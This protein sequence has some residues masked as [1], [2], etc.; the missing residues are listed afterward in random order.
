MSGI[1]TGWRTWVLA[2]VLWLLAP[3]GASASYTG[4]EVELV[5]TSDYGWSYRVYATFSDPAD[6]VVAVYGWAPAPMALVSA[7]SIYQHP[8]GA[9]TALGLNTAL[10]GAYPD[11]VYDSWFTIGSES[12]DGS[13]ALNLAGMGT[14]FDAFESGEGFVL[15]DP[16]GGTWFIAPDSSPEAFAGEEGRVLL[17]QFTVTGLTSWTFNVQ[18]VDSAG[19]T[20][21]EEGLVVT[22]PQDVTFGCMDEE[23]CN[24]DPV[25]EAEDGSC[26]YLSCLV[27]GCTDPLACN[28][29]P[30]ATADDGDC[31]FCSCQRT[32]A[33]TLTVESSPSVLPDKTVHRFY[34]NT[35]DASDRVSA[36]FGNN[37]KE[38]RVDAPAGVFNST[39]NNS[40]N[41]SGVNP[42]LFGLYPELADD[43]YA[44]VGLSGPAS[45]SPNNGALDASLVQDVDQPITPFFQEDDA[46]LLLS[47]TVTGALWYV[48]NT[49]PNG[50][51]DENN[52]VLVMQVTSGGP[53]S[54]QLNVQ[55][56]PL[57]VGEDAIEVTLPFDGAGEFGGEQNSA[58][59]GCTDELA[60]NFDSEAEY[61]S[62][63]CFYDVL[64]CGDP[65]A[66]NYEA[67]VTLD[68]GSCDY[69]SCVV[70][71]C[72]D[73]EADNYD[74][75]ATEDDGLCDYLGCTDLDALNPDLGANVDDGSCEYPAPSFQGLEVV[76]VSEGVPEEGQRTFRVYARFANPL[77]QVTAVYGD[78]DAPM[79][80]H[81]GTTLHQA[82]NGSAF[83]PDLPLSPLDQ[84]LEV[85]SWFTL[86]SDQPGGTMLNV[87]GMSSALSDFE[88]G[89]SW[90]VNSPSGGMWFVLPDMEEAAFPDPDGL[91][92]LGQFTTDGHVSWTLNL[93][94]AAQDG[95]F[96]SHEQLEVAFPQNLMPGCMDASACNFSPEAQ[97][98]N[99][100]CDFD[101]CVGCMDVLACNFEPDAT[102]DSQACEFPS[103][104][105]ACD[106]SCLNDSDG[107]GVCDPFEIEGCTQEA[108]ANFV[109]A[110][111][112]D[113]GTCQ[114]PGCT[115][116]EAENFDPSANLDDGS[117]EVL[118]CTDPL[119]LNFN[120]LATENDNS[121]TY[122]PPSFVGLEWDEVGETENGTPIY[123][124]YA[125]F[126]NPMDQLLAVYGDADDPLVLSSTM[127]F[128]Q[129]TGAGPF[130]FN[131]EAFELGA[132]DS[133][134]TLGAEP[135]ELANVSL[136]GASEGVL[137]FEENGGSLWANS[138]AGTAWFVFPDM[139]PLAFPDSTGRV[140]LAQLVTSG[141]VSWVLNLQHQSQGG[142]STLETGLS[143]VFPEGDPG[144]TSEGACNYSE[145]AQFEDG[146][147]EFPSPG[148]D[149][150]GQCLFDEDGD[151]TCDEFEIEGC[152]N[153]SSCNFDPQATDDNG[154]C[155]FLDLCGVCGGENES[156]S[157]CMDE[158]ADNFD[159]VALAED[160]SCV[161]L[162]CTDPEAD[163]FDEE[164]NVDDGLCE[165][166]GCT[167]PSAE[168]YNVLNQEDDGSCV[169]S[170]CTQ[171][172]AVNFNPHASLDD[173][174]CVVAGCTLS[175]ASNYN[176]SATLNDE[177]CIIPG[178]TF[179]SALNY[180]PVATD[181]DGSCLF[182]GCTAPEAANFSVEASLDD[183][184]C[185]FP[186]CTYEEASN[187]NPTANFDDGSCL[188]TVPM[189][190]GEGTI[191]DPEAGHCVLEVPM[192]LEAMEDGF[193]IANPCYF[194]AD[195]SGHI[196]IQDLFV[197]LTIY[198][199][200]CP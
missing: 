182:E 16:V 142:I 12:G 127:G 137:N 105:Y 8:Y 179:V 164:A 126:E 61:D 183:G 62:G 46:T 171:E 159:P 176:P 56:F 57:G 91:V 178:C 59:C 173:G 139:E 26:E 135:G 136:V 108:A 199:E 33:Y 138:P 200:L 156:C 78:E 169:F 49:A 28:Y 167:Y 112:E 60:A 40:W 161:W 197:F 155:L 74:P 84:E 32:S 128:E 71:G 150:F 1:V 125:S 153:S 146:S 133:W 21:N 20:F 68:D 25:A 120:V 116:A 85:D 72:T 9:S 54:G 194:D 94:Y 3:A 186:G 101:S 27:Y 38:L 64:G 41:P 192:Y 190:C 131:M 55:V 149:C 70:L 195:Q 166:I 98:E 160:G 76:Q 151:G 2:P 118:G 188:L 10:F 184:S 177:S 47:N 121:C 152:M 63:D 140:L 113:D 122:P 100:S 187:F 93:Q 50:L 181:D 148:Y 30:Y 174:S 48:L 67:D 65:V 163:N 22:F 5:A 92:L 147:C 109:P 42:A 51:P 7:S 4:V 154:S 53:L 39:F 111:T 44:T 14:S 107:D 31:D 123:R 45:L 15:D 43:T 141:Q 11:L 99:G 69:Q 58:L 82:P 172:E 115:L 17:G 88:S 86:G 90:E 83:A 79:S 170:G 114:F 29:I 23:A 24:F 103:E 95:S 104:G 52:R 97:V 75:N 119:A 162:G 134:L 6:Q 19:V 196:G 102:V 180:N 37:E 117:C 191:W 110:A 106:G 198:G 143:L 66:C 81:V 34:V 35:T 165:Y 168:N 36:V 87:V 73:S 175:Q 129:V 158:S 80:M 144:C 89:A 18:H 132:E 13:A 193:G 189:P 77:D 145:Q 124:V 130:A 96:L 157:G 185:E